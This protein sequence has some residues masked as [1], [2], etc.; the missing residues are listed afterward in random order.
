LDD[1]RVNALITLTRQIEMYAVKNK[2]LPPDLASLE[3]GSAG[4]RDPVTGSPYEY[5][6][7][8]KRTYQVCAGFEAA[9][10]TSGRP[11]SDAWM[12]PEGRHCFERSMSLDA[13]GIDALGL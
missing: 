9:S 8:D 13:A 4:P 3:P 7:K 2:A 10:S 5:A 6:L 12:H 11:N 1:V